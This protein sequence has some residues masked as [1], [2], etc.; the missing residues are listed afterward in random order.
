MRNANETFPNFEPKYRRSAQPRLVKVRKFVS[1]NKKKSSSSNS[2]SQQQEENFNFNF[3]PFRKISKEEGSIH[4]NDDSRFRELYNQ[5]NNHSDVDSFELGKFSSSSSHVNMEKLVDNEMRNLKIDPQTSKDCFFNSGGVFVFGTSNSSSVDMKLPYEMKNLNIGSN[6][7]HTFVFG[8]SGSV[9]F[10]LPHQMKNLNIGDTTGNVEFK[11]KGSDERRS[12]FRKNKNEASSFGVGESSLLPGELRKL[13]IGDTGSVGNVKDAGYVKFKAKG[14]EKKSFVLRKNRN[15]AG[16]FGASELS[17]LPNEMK[18]LNIDGLKGGDKVEESNDGYDKVNGTNVFGF[19]SDKK[20]TGSF[21]SSAVN[22]LPDEMNKLNVGS[23]SGDSNAFAD[24]ASTSSFDAQANKSTERVSNDPG[25]GNTMHGSFSFQAAKPSRSSSVGSDHP[26]QPNDDSKSSEAST[27]SYSFHTAGVSFQSSGS[28]FEESTA[29]SAVNTVDS[30]VNKAEFAFGAPRADLRTPPQDSSRSSTEKL[31][32][33]MNQKLEFSAK[34]GAVKDL[35]TK[36]KKGKT[37]EPVKI[38]LWAGEHNISSENSYKESLESS[39][40]YSPMD[41]SPY[42]ETLAVDKSHGDASMASDDFFPLDADRPLADAHSSVGV[43]AIDADWITAEESLNINEDTSNCGNPDKEKDVSAECHSDEFVSGLKG[44]RPRSKTETG[45]KTDASVAAKGTDRDLHTH[46]ESKGDDGRIPFCFASNSQDAS[47]TNFTFAA[48]TTTHGHTSA[49][50]RHYKKK[51]W[52]KVGQDSYTSTLNAKLQFASPDKPFFPLPGGSVVDMNRKGDPSISQSIGE[53][54]AESVA[55][56]AHEAC[57]KWRLRGNQ[58]YANG[59]LSNAE[60]YYT[61]GLNCVPENETSESCLTAL[62][63]CYSNRAAT[64]MSSGRTREALDD[65]K[66]A[67]EINPDFRKVQVRAANCHLLLGEVEDALK[68]FKDS[69]PPG[70]DLC[71]DRKLVI[72]ASNGLQKAQQVG[73]CLNRCAELLHRRTLDDAEGAL[74]LIAKALLIS[75]YSE[76][77]IEMKAEAFLTLRKYEEVIQL[78]EQSLDSADKNSSSTSADRSES[79]KNCPARLWRWHL[80][81]KSYF[82]LGRLEETL[83]L[84]EKLERAESEAQRIGNKITEPWSKLAVTVRELLRHKAAGNE[85]FQSG[86]HSEAIEHY[87]SALSCNLESRPFA[88]ICFCN[89]AAAH[90]ALGQITDAIADCSLAIALD[91]NYPKAISRRATLHEMIRDYGQAAIDLERLASL[92]ERQTEEKSNQSGKL[93]RSTSGIIDLRQAHSRLSTMEEEARKGI[94]LDL[95]LILKFEKAGQILP[96]SENGNDGVWKEVAEERSQYDDEEIRY[97]KKDNVCS[98]SRASD[99]HSYPFERNGSR[100]Q[101]QEAIQ[102]CGLFVPPKDKK[103]HS[104]QSSAK[105]K[106]IEPLQDRVREQQLKRMNLLM[107]L[108][109]RKLSAKVFGQEIRTHDLGPVCSGGNARE[110]KG[111]E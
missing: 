90:Q 107:C 80:M 12:V 75:P 37:R 73:Q 10:K 66:K 67:A 83:T 71:L 33:G 39:G 8:Q 3:N 13:N 89:R 92:L 57:E 98:T 88:A 5:Y 18:K 109:K 62:M 45:S 94:P 1:S 101:W 29:D 60:D 7:A 15:D 93:G 44:G 47:G 55:R 59:E 27:S 69:L 108:N 70:A 86:R 36:K 65:C 81:A 50:K 11:A 91:G 95:Y 16:S 48:A 105:G 111:K 42:P 41:V 35:R 97:T 26:L 54:R 102:P 21:S 17:V 56:V 30:A 24:T 32:T 74:Q 87:T 31:F 51:N 68:Y 22:M 76:R 23:K 82:Y 96:R 79:I 100:K 106:P 19:G 34:K 103:H 9:D 99:V 4:V 43:D 52:L 20:E 104:F 28:A 61:R 46:V 2:N 25:I 78:C 6:A 14:S 58:A 77:L 84:M 40:C 38:H 85:A 49:A 64:R 63:L 72:E 53:N 110:R